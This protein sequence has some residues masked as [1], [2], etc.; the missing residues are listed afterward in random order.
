MGH[1]ISDA[2]LPS[3]RKQ[4]ALPVLTTMAFKSNAGTKQA[5]PTYT[6]QQSTELVIDPVP[7]SADAMKYLERI[8]L[9]ELSDDFVILDTRLSHSYANKSMN[10]TTFSSCQFTVNFNISKC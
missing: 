3:A 10:P 7:Q 1:S 9:N 2:M 5:L 8:C 4:L 6:S